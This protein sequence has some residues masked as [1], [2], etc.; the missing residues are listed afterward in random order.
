MK[1]DTAVTVASVAPAALGSWFTLDKVASVVT[2]I[3]AILA[4]VYLIYKWRKEILEGRENENLPEH[5]D[6]QETPE[7]PKHG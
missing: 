5:M 4:G 6:P 3:Y 7:T 1:Q 2:I